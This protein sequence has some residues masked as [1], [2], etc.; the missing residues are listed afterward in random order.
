MKELPGKHIKG[1]EVLFFF[2]LSNLVYVFML[3]VTIPEVMNFSG[4][5]K[6]PDMLPGGYSYEYVNLLMATLGEKGR[7][8]YLFHQLPV[9]MVFPFLFGVSN[10]L[11][12]AYLLHRMDKLEGS[13]VYLC[14]LPLLAGGFDY[15]ENLGIVALLMS[16][17]DVS[18]AL[19][20][21]TGLF[22]ILKSAL[23]AF[24]F[25]VLII[26]LLVWGIGYFK[27]NKA[28]EVSK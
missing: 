13:F 1:R 5:M 24:Y 7:Q 11:I 23:T 14:L 22:T 8:A 20:T 15:L 21:V 16:Y 26:T 10:C 2:F 3:T 18:R 12:L 28:P 6:L 17:P 25:V 27:K 4:G 19:T 9:D